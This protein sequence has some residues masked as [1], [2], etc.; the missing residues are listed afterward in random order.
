MIDLRPEDFHVDCFLI[1]GHATSDSNHVTIF[2]LGEMILE[3]N[4]PSCLAV[5]QLVAFYHPHPLPKALVL[6][7]TF[8]AKLLLPDWPPTHP[9]TKYTLLKWVSFTLFHQKIHLY[10]KAS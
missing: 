6:F 4:S 8:S 3:G 7:T 2:S 9:A 5:S 10:F 1:N